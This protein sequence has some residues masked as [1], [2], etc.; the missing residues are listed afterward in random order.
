MSS[1]LPP[2]MGFLDKAKKIS[3]KSLEVG[4]DIGKK[5]LEK[6]MDIAKHDTEL[7]NVKDLPPGDEILLNTDFKVKTGLVSSEKYFLIITD[8]NLFNVSGETNKIVGKYDLSKITVD[9]KNRQVKSRGASGNNT[10]TGLDSHKS[11][12]EGEVHVY[13]DGKEIIHM[14]RKKN[15]DDLANDIQRHVNRNLS[16]T[17]SESA[18][19]TTNDNSNSDDPLTM[20]KKRLVNGEISKEEFEEMKKLIE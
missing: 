8:K 3:K 18:V 4:T 16:N 20:L 10:W 6:G 13:N 15:P 9:V 5:G 17:S 12:D 11:W 7:P 2:I 14:N 19:L 1:I